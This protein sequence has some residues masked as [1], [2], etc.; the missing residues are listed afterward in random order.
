[1]FKKAVLNANKM[2]VILLFSNTSFTT[3]IPADEKKEKHMDARSYY[4]PFMLGS[5]LKFRG[6]PLKPTRMASMEKT[7]RS[8]KCPR[9]FRLILGYDTIFLLGYNECELLSV[10]KKH[11]HT[12]LS[13]GSSENLIILN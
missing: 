12:R 10:R 4:A 6:P 2:A 8:I 3:A 9:E 13:S 5:A 1:M 7:L 11:I